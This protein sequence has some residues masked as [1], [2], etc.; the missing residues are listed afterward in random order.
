MKRM[1]AAEDSMETRKKIVT[2]SALAGSVFG[3]GIMSAGLVIAGCGGT[4][5]TPELRDARAAMEEARA[6]SAASLKPGE[7]RVAERT[8]ARAEAAPDASPAEADLAYVAERQTR[9]A[10]AE[11][12]RTQ[13]EQQVAR[14]QEQYR[15]GLEAMARARGERIE[16][17]EARLAEEQRQLAAREQT[18]EEQRRTI[19]EGQAALEAEQ[20]ARQEAEQRA[21]DS[22]TRLRELAA[23]REGRDETVITLSGEVIFES[24]RADLR[25]TARERLVAL[26]DALRAQPNQVAVIEGH[27]DSRGS[28]GYNLRLSQDRADA[29]REQLI[30]EGVPAARLQAV[31]RGEDQ[32]IASND[33][34]EGRALN[35]RVE[36]HLRPIPGATSEQPIQ[37]VPQ[38]SE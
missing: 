5:I 33:D 37:A 15:R 7:L 3:A 20:R 6:S 2:R 4:A 19:A 32:P 1:H 22:M 13:L 28:D 10:M 29:V 11:A 8:L 18:L 26:A 25:V 17:T 30:A 27:T 9:I 31:G 38:Q 24:D 21:E 35:R 14:D 34:A 12:R 36:V 16:Q 23:V